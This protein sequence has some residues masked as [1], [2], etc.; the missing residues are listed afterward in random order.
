MAVASGCKQLKT[1]NLSRCFQI[2]DEA[3][4]AVTASGCKQLTYRV[5]NSKSTT[6]LST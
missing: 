1:L 4:T 5:I 2:T 3:V 6:T